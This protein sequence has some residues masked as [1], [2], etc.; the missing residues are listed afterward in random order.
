MTE[1]EKPNPVQEDDLFIR[2]Q[3][4]LNRDRNRRTLELLQGC[5]TPIL[6]ASELQAQDIPTLDIEPPKPHGFGEHVKDGLSVLGLGV[7][8]PVGLLSFA[9]TE[10]G[11]LNLITKQYPASPAITAGSALVTAVLG[12]TIYRLTKKIL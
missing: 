2:I 1:G 11:L 10:E 9:F 5:N 3:S 6:S 12:V 4:E 7:V 8:F